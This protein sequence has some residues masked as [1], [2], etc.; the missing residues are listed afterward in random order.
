MHSLLSRLTEILNHPEIFV[1]EE[2]LKQAKAAIRNK[3]VFLYKTPAQLLNILFRLESHGLKNNYLAT[4][5][6][7]I[8]QVTLEDVLNIAKKYYNFD[9]FLKVIVAPKTL[10]LKG[11]TIPFDISD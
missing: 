7:N 6:E 11:K 2:K 4:F 1:T 8:E 9:D 5:L 10:N 3:F